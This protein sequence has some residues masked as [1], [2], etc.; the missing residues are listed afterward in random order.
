MDKSWNLETRNTCQEHL[1]ASV[2]QNQDKQE[3]AKEKNWTSVL[4]THTNTNEI[5]NE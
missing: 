4:E 1:S 5:R 3:V 2:L